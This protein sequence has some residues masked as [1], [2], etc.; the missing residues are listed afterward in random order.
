MA[1]GEERGVAPRQEEQTIDLP[2]V[3]GPEMPPEP[4]P[5]PRRRGRTV[6]EGCLAR[7]GLRAAVAFLLFFLGF[8][9]LLIGVSQMIRQAA[10]GTDKVEW[11][12][13]DW[14]ET[15]EFRDCV[16]DYLAYLVNQ[17]APGALEDGGVTRP[18]WKNQLRQDEQ[19]FLWTVRRSDSILG[20]SED[21][22][23]LSS[24]DYNEL[25]WEGYSFLLV[26]EDGRVIITMDGQKLNIYGDGVY[27][28]GD[29]WKVPGY[30]NFQAGSE[31]RKLTVVL[32]VR[33]HPSAYMGTGTGLQKPVVSRLYGIYTGYREQRMFWSGCIIMTVAGALLLTGGL[34]LRRDRRRAAALLARGGARV[35][36]EVRALAVLVCLIWTAWSWWSWT[37]LPWLALLVLAW[38]VWL[39]GAIG[40][41]IPPEGRRSLLG[42][43]GV[44][45]PLKLQRRVSRWN[46]T[47]AVAVC[48]PLVAVALSVCIL[49]GWPS[50]P[51]WSWIW[52]SYAA[53]LILCLTAALLAILLVWRALYWGRRGVE[54]VDALCRHI[55]AVHD[56]N[57]TDPVTLPASSGLEEVAEQLDDIRAGL[58][59]ALDEATRSER[60]KVELITN[61]SHDLKTPLTAILTYADLLAREEDV[62]NHVRDYARVIDQKA[63][64]LS[65]MVADV[66]DLSKAAAGQLAVKRQR[67]DLAKL[68]RQTLADMDEE[69]RAGPVLLRTALPDDPVPIVAD[70]DRLYRVFQNLFQNMLQYS[71]EGSRAYLELTVE[72]GKAQ[73]SLRN[74]SREELPAGVDL[75][76]RFT[77]GD[78]SRSDGG[79]GL[80]LAIADSFTRACGG[81]FRVETQGD[82]FWAFV[83]FPLAEKEPED[84][85]GETAEEPGEACSAPEAEG[86]TDL[87]VDNR[88]QME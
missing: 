54:D 24:E 77:R 33:D 25:A 16:T 35:W 22:D 6:L 76:A 7:P 32:A 11:W 5:R 65:T 45:G 9:L 14:R 80:G 30:D 67:L 72:D 85:E 62:P 18:T 42:L 52:N 29:Q 15:Q 39:A 27:R 40:R 49:M 26:L 71:L 20:S 78:A 47:A 48:L 31:L 23:D 88:P 68:L 60:M 58:E 59:R 21:H 46:R 53:V 12:K 64:R 37:G 44:R 10:A 38:L 41:Y 3:D 82:L 2:G 34:V 83:T 1:S 57:V 84:A 13:S 73:V 4:G 74:I 75:T 70:G 8:S 51:F 56:G 63:R 66:F 87:P 79:S 61:V 28:G 50:F 81:A 69:L 17:W 36:T 55:A 19:N 86:K 43:V